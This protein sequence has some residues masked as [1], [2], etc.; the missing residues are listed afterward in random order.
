MKNPSRKGSA[1]ERAICRRLSE[2]WSSGS[3]TDIFWRTTTSGARATTRATKGKSTYG[4][5][6]DIQAT[7][8]VGEPLLQ[9]ICFELKCGYPAVSVGDLLDTVDG[10]KVWNQW[11]K[12][13]KRSAEGAKSHYWMIVSKKGRRQSM[14]IY[15]RGLDEVFKR[16]GVI[17]ENYLRT[18]GWFRCPG[19]AEVTSDLIITPLEDVLMA[20]S[21]GDVHKIIRARKGYE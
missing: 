1:F 13:A 7:D 8:P 12:K 17:V 11:I 5:Y 21:P 15:P 9:L 3:R 20:V 14:A 16:D 2:W 6:G 4:Q 19:V 18:C 10:G